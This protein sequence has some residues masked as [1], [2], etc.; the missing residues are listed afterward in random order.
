M[1][2]DMSAGTPPRALVRFPPTRGWPTCRPARQ[3]SG[4]HHRGANGLFRLQF[5][6][7][8]MGKDEVSGLMNKLRGEKIVSLASRAVKRGRPATPILMVPRFH[9]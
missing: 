2:R 3:L 9:D 1:T 8:S 4:D 5:G 6:S 7:K